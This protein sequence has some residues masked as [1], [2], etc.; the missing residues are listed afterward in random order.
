MKAAC[1]IAQAYEKRQ[2]ER[3]HNT[4]LLLKR[5]RDTAMSLELS[6]D[7]HQEDFIT[8]YG[9]NVT[10]YLDEI[11]VAGAE[12]R[13]S[14]LERHTNTLKRTEHMLL[15]VRKAINII[16]ENH[17]NGEIYYWIMHY[18]YLC[19]HKELP[20]WDASTNR[21]RPS[22]RNIIDWID[23]FT[24]VQCGTS[25]FFYDKRKE[26]IEVLS[27]VLWGFETRD[28]AELWELIC[29]NGTNL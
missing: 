23:T 27:S 5:Y 20:H 14:K 4:E 24:P 7:E 11:Y 3:Y 12:L 10:Q 1:K 19:P 2:K 17:H 6:V 15:L 25:K 26:A 29:E 22:V 28:A 9:M 21:K 18:T 16:R 13:G 8:E